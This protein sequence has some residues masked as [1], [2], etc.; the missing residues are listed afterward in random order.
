VGPITSITLL[1]QL[2]TNFSIERKL[3]NLSIS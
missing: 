1:H 3:L 2:G